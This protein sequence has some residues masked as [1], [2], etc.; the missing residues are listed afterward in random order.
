MNVLILG[1]DGQVGRELVRAAWNGAALVTGLARPTVDLTRMET[2]EAALS[3]HAPD[4]VINAAAYT[5]VDRAERDRETAF[6]VNSD[7]PGYLAGACRRQG[8]PL[9]HLSTDYVFDGK[10]TTP[11]RENDPTGPINAYGLSKASGEAAVRASQPQHIIL[12]TSWVYASHGHNFLRTMLRLARER[13]EVAVVADQYGAPTAA[14]DIAAALV[15]IARRVAAHS[16][17][18]GDE[19]WGTYHFTA[20]GQ[21]TWHGIAEHIFQHYER[22]S[23]RRPTLKAIATSEYPLPARRPA[24]TCLDCKRIQ[25]V[26]GIAASLWSVSLDFVLNELLPPPER[27]A[28]GK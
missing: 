13:D 15:T 1:S 24:Y 16:N 18:V 20:Q 6:A 9:I 23:G 4:V 11:Y 21:T 10:A 27:E 26:F 12:R 8:V 17:R 22:V 3:R 5:S 25:H 14:R 7:G 19:A 28:S 2:I